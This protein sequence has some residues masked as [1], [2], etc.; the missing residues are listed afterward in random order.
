MNILTPA[1][2]LNTAS[3][4]KTF[5]LL[6]IPKVSSRFFKRVLK[7]VINYGGNLEDFLR[8]EEGK[9]FRY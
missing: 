7:G 4:E 1:D 6:S 9:K 3:L 2:D 8:V 5:F